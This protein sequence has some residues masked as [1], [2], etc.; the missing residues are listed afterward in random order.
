MESMNLV[1]IGI[2]DPDTIQGM[3]LNA[4]F[5]DLDISLDF[6]EA[7]RTKRFEVLPPDAVEAPLPIRQLFNCRRMK[8]LFAGRTVKQESGGVVN[9]FAYG[10]GELKVITNFGNGGNYIFSVPKQVDPWGIR[11]NLV[12]EE[13]C[14]N[15]RTASHE[16]DNRW[17]QADIRRRVGVDLLYSNTP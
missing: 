11:E 14:N 4:K 6:D 10:K 16:L 9:L 5:R 2:T 8:D 12:A 1:W 3:Q 13:T 7:G 17:R 15:P